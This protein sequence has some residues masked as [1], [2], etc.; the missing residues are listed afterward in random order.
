MWRN[1][2]YPGA[3]IISISKYVMP[4]VLRSP[5]ASTTRCLRF[6]VL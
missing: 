6:L 3:C 5:D 4:P 1:F 2:F